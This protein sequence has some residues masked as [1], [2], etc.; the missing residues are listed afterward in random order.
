MVQSAHVDAEEVVVVL[1]DSVHGSHAVALTEGVVVVAVVVHGSHSVLLAVVVV[2]V[3]VVHGSHSV[4]LAVV[5]VVVVVVVHGS[6]SV[7]VALA[8][9]V[10]VVVVFLEELEELEELDQAETEAARPAMMTAERI[11]IV[12]DCSKKIEKV[13]D[14]GFVLE[15]NV[16]ELVERMD[17]RSQMMILCF[18]LR[19]WEER[20]NGGG[21]GACMPL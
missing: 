9:V 1:E 5:V 14:R 21:S 7:L 2:V 4:L 13:E 17:D 16:M 8:V 19:E 11:L 20:R 18:S 3:L 12:F 6:H 15:A 10:V